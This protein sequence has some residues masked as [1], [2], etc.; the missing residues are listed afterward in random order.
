MMELKNIKMTKA[1]ILSNAETLLANVTMQRRRFDV[2]TTRYAEAKYRASVIAYDNDKSSTWYVLYFSN[3]MPKE[4]DAV[5]SLH[6]LILLDLGKE[7]KAR[8]ASPQS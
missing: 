7:I 8:R 1:L 6:E 4:G 5:Q 2:V 3:Y